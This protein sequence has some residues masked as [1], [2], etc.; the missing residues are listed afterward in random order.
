[1]GAQQGSR[2]LQRRTLPHPED[3]RAFG[4]KRFYWYMFLFASS[5]WRHCFEVSS[6]I[7]ICVSQHRFIFSGFPQWSVCKAVESYWSYIKQNILWYLIYLSV[8]SF[9]WIMFVFVATVPNSSI[10]TSICCYNVLWATRK[11]C[12]GRLWI[13]LCSK[14]IYSMIVGGYYY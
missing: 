11:W 12:D 9:P 1:M 4:K 13:S 10:P 14:C 8:P 3:D 7:M 6:V 5:E 2:G